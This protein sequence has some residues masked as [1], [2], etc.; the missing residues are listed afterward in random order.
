MQSTTATQKPRNLTATRARR[1]LGAANLLTELVT[2]EGHEIEV[3]VKRE[4][5]STDRDLTDFH[6]DEVV[7]ALRD[8]GYEVSELRTGY[9]SWILDGRANR[10][11]RPADDLDYS[12]PASSAHY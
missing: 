8:A 11:S 6:R 5:G 10:S 2:I 4:D 3:H 9:G 12:N 7:A 1:V